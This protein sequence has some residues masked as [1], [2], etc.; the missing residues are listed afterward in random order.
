[1]L[2]HWWADPVPRALA[3]GPWGSWSSCG[4]AGRQ[5]HFLTQLATGSGVSQALCWP[6]G[7]R[8]QTPGGWPIGPQCLRAG[9][10][11]RVGSRAR[12]ARAHAGLLVGGLGPTTADCRA[13]LVLRLVFTHWCFCPGSWSMRFCVRPVRVGFLFPT[14]LWNWSPKTKPCWPSETNVLGLIFPGQDPRAGEPSVE[15]RPIAPW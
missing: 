2:A 14:V 15:L 5:G 3:A 8:D 11:P 9:V 1:M 4:S 13:A 10:G 6:T 7:G 12:W